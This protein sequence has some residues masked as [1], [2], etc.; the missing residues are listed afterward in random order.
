MNRKDPDGRCRFGDTVKVKFESKDWIHHPDRNIDLSVLPLLPRFGDLNIDMQKEMFLKFFNRSIP[1][2]DTWEMF[3]PM[4]DIVMIDF[5]NGFYDERNNAPVVRKG[6]TA[7]HP[8][9]NYKDNEAFWIDVTIYPG[10]S[11]SPVFV[12][13]YGLKFYKTGGQSH[14]AKTYFLGVLSAMARYSKYKPG[15][16]VGFIPSSEDS[17]GRDI[18]IVISSLGYVIKAT[19][20]KDFDRLLGEGNDSSR[21]L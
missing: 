4:E 16:E 19:R 18:L 7:T 20:L 6:V 13:V 3:S 12:A 10:M 17:P 2:Q 11:G 15:I 5:P 8:K 1:D 21:L 14:G 9:L